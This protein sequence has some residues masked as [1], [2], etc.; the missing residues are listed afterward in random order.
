MAVAIAAGC[1]Q[2]MKIAVSLASPVM[3]MFMVDKHEGYWGLSP[4]RGNTA[5]ESKVVIGVVWA[6]TRR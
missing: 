2:E 6:C 1:L 5:R 3:Y 4:R